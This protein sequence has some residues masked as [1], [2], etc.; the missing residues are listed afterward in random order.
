MDKD[1]SALEDKMLRNQQRFDHLARKSHILSKMEARSDPS[2]L[3]L[4]RRINR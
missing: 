1:S 3:E 2:E 4:V